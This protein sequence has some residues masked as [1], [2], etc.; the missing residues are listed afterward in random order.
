MYR[1]KEV[2]ILIDTQ[3]YDKKDQD[4]LTPFAA[5]CQ[6]GS[7]KVVEKLMKLVDRS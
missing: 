7:V 6:G 3:D 5:A 1:V 4:E 2:W